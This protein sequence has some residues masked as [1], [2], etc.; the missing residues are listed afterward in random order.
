MYCY[1]FQRDPRLPILDIDPMDQVKN[2]RIA[3]CLY[4]SANTVAVVAGFMASCALYFVAQDHL[5]NPDS[6]YFVNYLWMAYLEPSFIFL[7]FIMCDF[8]SGA[9]HL[10]SSYIVFV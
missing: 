9:S 4:V 7:G 8:G 2:W 6:P 10:V 1:P 3:Y 5:F